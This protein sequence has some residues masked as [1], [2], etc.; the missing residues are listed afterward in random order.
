ML[1]LK[2]QYFGYLIR[3][4]NS[5]EKSLILGKIGRKRRGNQRMR[6]LNG[7]TDALDVNLDKLWEMVRYKE[8][9]T[10]YP[11]TPLVWYTSWSQK[12]SGMTEQ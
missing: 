10:L 8:P 2:L 12:E 5:L 9:W 4:A 7:I 3:T 11:A 1:K 6:W